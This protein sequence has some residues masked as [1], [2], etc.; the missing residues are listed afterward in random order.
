MWD[1][2]K[3][4]KVCEVQGATLYIKGFM[5]VFTSNEKIVLMKFKTIEKM[6]AF[7]WKIVGS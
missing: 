6:M 5:L 4:N 1:P 7:I 3:W 2:S